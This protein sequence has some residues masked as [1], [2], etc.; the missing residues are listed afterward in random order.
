VLHRIVGATEISVNSLHGK[1]IDV[2]ADGLAVE[3]VAEDGVIEAVSVVNS[4][5][6][7]LGVQWHPEWYAATDPVARGILAA[8]G[9]ACHARFSLTRRRTA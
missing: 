7:A 1:A 5:A 4:T 8:F 9:S 3:A 2:L 6:F